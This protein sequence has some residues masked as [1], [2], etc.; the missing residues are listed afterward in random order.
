GLILMISLVALTG[1]VTGI[2]VYIRLLLMFIP[3]LL[4][5]CIKQYTVGL[6]ILCLSILAWYGEAFVIIDYNLVASLLIMVRSGIVTRFLP[7]IAMGYYIFK[8]SQ[9]EV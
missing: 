7:P 3:P 5:L 6:I 4:L 1:G 2:E 8:T 9:N